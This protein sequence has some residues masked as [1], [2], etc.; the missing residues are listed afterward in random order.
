MSWKTK[1]QNKVLKFSFFRKIPVW[2]TK[3]EYFE[4]LGKMT[5][6]KFSRE[7]DFFEIF[8]KMTA[9]IFSEKMTVSKFVEKCC[10][11]VFRKKECFDSN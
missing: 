5:V 11:Y 6:F 7:N 4:V 8:K 2:F 10:S 9:L 1:P 3:N